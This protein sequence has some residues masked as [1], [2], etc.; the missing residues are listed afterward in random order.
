MISIIICSINKGFLQDLTKNIKK[1]IG[2]PYQLI[3]I[4]NSEGNKGISEVYNEGIT[5][6]QHEILCFMHEDIAI[7][8]NNWGQIL[9]D[10]FKDPQLGL[11][12]LAGSS[13]RPLT[14]S[15]WSGFSPTSIY[16]N[17]LQS[18]KFT[19]KEDLHD[20]VNPNNAKLEKVICV[21]GV[22]LST[23]KNIATNL[24]FDSDTFLD[25]HG[26]DIDLSLSIGQKHKIAV[27]YDILINHL[28]EG[29]FNSKWMEDNIRL[30]NKWNKILPYDLEGRFTRNE[31]IAKEKAA[32]KEFVDLLIALNFTAITA[33]KVLWKNNSFY[34]LSP[35]LFFKLNF[36]VYKKFYR[37]KLNPLH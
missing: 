36:Y 25:F 34:K 35:K 32:F 9:I 8:T 2:V 23:T 12:G 22:W 5:L 7:K 20:Y 1:T 3:A 26:Y 29:N 33:F 28:S 30:F 6:A 15:N 17:I 14:P 4:N 16:M 37:N 27:T 11:V 31:I 10:L 13:Y 19:N 21:D 24:K 18:F